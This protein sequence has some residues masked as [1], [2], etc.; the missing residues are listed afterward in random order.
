MTS[1]VRYFPVVKKGFDLAKQALL[2]EYTDLFHESNASYS[3]LLNGKS[4]LDV[5]NVG[6]PNAEF[7]SLKQQGFPPK[8]THSL[9]S[10]V[11]DTQLEILTELA[12]SHVLP[13]STTETMDHIIDGLR[14]I[15]REIFDINRSP[16]VKFFFQIRH[17]KTGE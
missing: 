9:A 12:I 10:R 11:M 6:S 15:T 2:K 4:K 1:K 14:D 17:K 5:K 13:S 16:A 7:E 3:A 8:E